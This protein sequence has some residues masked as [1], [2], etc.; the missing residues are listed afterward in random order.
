MKNLKENKQAEPAV[1]TEPTVDGV[2][3]QIEETTEPTVGDGVESKAA[4]SNEAVDHILAMY[5]NY[6]ELAIDQ[7]GGVYTKDTK[8]LSKGEAILY[9]NPYF[10]S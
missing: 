6:D 5:P 9:K 7:Y 2:T 3:E 10:K 4:G 1:Q 8:H